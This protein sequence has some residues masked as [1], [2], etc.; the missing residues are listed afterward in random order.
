VIC[1]VFVM[2]EDN[3]NNNFVNPKEFEGHDC[4]LDVPI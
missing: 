2:M 3:V 4:Q 1:E